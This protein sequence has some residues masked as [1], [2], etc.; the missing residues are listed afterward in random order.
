MMIKKNLCY[1]LLIDDEEFVNRIY[2]IVILSLKIM[3]NRGEERRK[4]C[5]RFEDGMEL[6]EILENSSLGL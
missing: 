1:F 5:R 3:G 4:G 2:C 6:S